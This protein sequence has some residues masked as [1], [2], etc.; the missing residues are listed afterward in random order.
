MFFKKTN[1]MAKNVNEIE[2]TVINM[3]AS[4][5][6]I[7]G[8]VKSNGDIRIDG[9]LIGSVESKGKIVIGT[10]GSVEGEIICQNGV[11]SGNIKAKVTVTELLSLLSTAKLTGDILTNKLSIEPGARFSGNCTMQDESQRSNKFIDP[12][13]AANKPKEK[14]LETA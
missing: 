3:I 7:K 6:I 5:T 12:N 9:T 11:F 1:A 14:V 4:G 8:D 2:T 10:T 13:A